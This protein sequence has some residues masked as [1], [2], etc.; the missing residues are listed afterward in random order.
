MLVHAA[1]Q[2][3]IYFIGIVVVLRAVYQELYS[4][5]SAAESLAPGCHLL[6]S[7]GFPLFYCSIQVYNNVRG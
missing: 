5:F 2:H 6:L 4:A 3:P 7:F 1:V